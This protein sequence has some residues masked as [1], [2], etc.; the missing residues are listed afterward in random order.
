M[1]EIIVYYL[2]RERMSGWIGT[3]PILDSCACCIRYSIND[4][5][6]SMYARVIHEFRMVINRIQGLITSVNHP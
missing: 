2:A 3:I 1:I 6:A 5:C 4:T